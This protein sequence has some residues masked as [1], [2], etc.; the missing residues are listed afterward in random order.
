MNDHGE[1]GK[2][3]WI[4]EMG[5]STLTVSEATRATF[6]QQA[7][8][9]VRSWPRVVVFCAYQLSE[10]Q[11]RPD[12]GMVAPDGTAS[13]SWQAYAGAVAAR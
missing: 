7:V 12:Y 4:T 8:G 6:Y 10:D 9:L 5:W 1:S 3:I 2:P 11:D 13:A